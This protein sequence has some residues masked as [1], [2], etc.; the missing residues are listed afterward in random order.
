MFWVEVCITCRSVAYL[1]LK[2]Y[3][4]RVFLLSV[5]QVMSDDNIILN[6]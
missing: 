4:A 5:W 2:L 6:R 3:F 1:V